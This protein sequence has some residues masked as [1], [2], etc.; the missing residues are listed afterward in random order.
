MF[1]I[2]SDIIID[3]FKIN[4]K[5][6][7]PPFLAVVLGCILRHCLDFVL[8]R[9]YFF[10]DRS[11]WYLAV[12]CFPWLEEAVYED[13]PQTISQQSQAQQ[14]QHNN[15]TI[16]DKHNVNGVFNG[17]NNGM[18]RGNIMTLKDNIVIYYL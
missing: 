9:L 16:G 4:A 14:S 17:N 10:F 12:I 15:K 13:F 5:F 2:I 7:T 18:I 8:L 6:V 11:H 1:Y 3:F